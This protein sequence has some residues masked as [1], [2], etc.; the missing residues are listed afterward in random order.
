MRFHY[1]LTP[2]LQDVPRS[3]PAPFSELEGFLPE[4]EDVSPLG[5][6]P[7]SS[8]LTTLFSGTIYFFS[9][10]QLG[11][12][13]SE[14]YFEA[15]PPNPNQIFHFSLI[16]LASAVSIPGSPPPCCL[17]CAFLCLAQ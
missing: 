15:P 6:L 1:I 13:F 16:L 11:A 14:K 10:S 9:F 4:K 2:S 7:Q 3:A 5:S 8:L 17:G 12:R